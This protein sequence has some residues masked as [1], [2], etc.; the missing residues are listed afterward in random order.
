MNKK[1]IISSI[2]LQEN[3]SALKFRIKYVARTK[4]IKVYE[5]AEKINK[6]RTYISKIDNGNVNTTIEVLQ[7]IANALEVPVHELIE[8]PKGYGHFY[9]DGEWQGIRKV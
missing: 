4:G 8:C 9:V 3:I 5:L 7:S 6:G 2:S 1:K